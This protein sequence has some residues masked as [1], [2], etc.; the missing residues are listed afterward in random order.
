[1]KDIDFDDD[2]T[3]LATVAYI[4]CDSIQ[5]VSLKCIADTAGE[6]SIRIPHLQNEPRAYRGLA[7][8]LSLFISFPPV[9]MDERW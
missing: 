7:S 9:N 3:L 2:R 4:R 1:M 5:A 8:N 6:R